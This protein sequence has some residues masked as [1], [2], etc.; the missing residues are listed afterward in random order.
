MDSGAKKGAAT[1]LRYLDIDSGSRSLGEAALVDSSG[2]IWKSGLVFDNGLIDE[3]ATCHIA[4]GSA[5]FDVFEGAEAMDEA[6]RAAVGFNESLVHID[7]MIGSD[8][9]DVTGLRQGGG[10]MDIIRNGKFV[11]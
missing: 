4:L 1:L 8:E 10:A 2:P 11:I 5:Y 9:V 7:F 3:N 6:G